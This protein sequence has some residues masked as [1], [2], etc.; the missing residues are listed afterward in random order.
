MCIRPFYTTGRKA[1]REGVGFVRPEDDMSYSV[2]PDFFAEIFIQVRRGGQAQA[3]AHVSHG[4]AIPKPAATAAQG[5]KRLRMVH[6][7][8]SFWKCWYGAMLRIGMRI[9]SFYS[10]VPL[11][12]F[13]FRPHGRREDP[14]VAQRILRERLRRIGQPHVTMLTDMKNASGAVDQSAVIRD[15][16]GMVRTE[17][18]HVFEQ[19]FTNLVVR[20]KARDGESEFMP[21]RGVL[22]GTCEGPAAF[23][24]SFVQA[25]VGRNI[26]MGDR[27]GACRQH[28]GGNRLVD[29]GVG[30]FADDIAKV[31]KIVDTAPESVV[32][33]IDAFMSALD[34]HTGS[35]GMAQQPSKRDIVLYLRS[36][37]RQRAMQETSHGPTIR[38]SAM[39]LGEQLSL[40]GS[41]QPELQKAL[42]RASSVVVADAAVSCRRVELAISPYRVQC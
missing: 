39:H 13:G 25:V 12:V 34:R 42:C 24:G 9:T 19:R 8:C 11:W 7:L 16:G 6:M 37:A 28:F 32:S 36:A 22:M 5:V 33:Q 10:H 23:N 41:N 30:V 27:T 38:T 31:A 15:V 35:I 14:M 2:V 1:V 17:V 21:R 3:I 20:V 26:E 40:N 4:H 18:K 29:V